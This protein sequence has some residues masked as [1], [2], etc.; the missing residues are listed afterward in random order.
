MVIQAALLDMDGI[1]VDSEPLHCKAWSEVAH[2]MGASLPP[3]FFHKYVGIGNTKVAEDLISMTKTELSKEEIVEQKTNVYL[4]LIR[5]I[6]PMEGIVEFLTKLK[7]NHLSIGVVSS[8][9]RK[10]VVSTLQYA[11]IFSFFE[12][13]T[14]KE[15]AR[16]TKP[17]PDLYKAALR[18]MNLQPTECV[19]VEDSESGVGAAKSAGIYCIAIPHKLSASQNF[20]KA[21][22]VIESVTILLGHNYDK[23]RTKNP[24]IGKLLG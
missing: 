15:D 7:K 14:S 2:F 24:L 5:S 16:E 10:E 4:G 19:A 9:P 11:G 21:D 8:S 1:L 12:T 6:K 23:M 3:E 18:K 22:L 13:V 17:A 20:K